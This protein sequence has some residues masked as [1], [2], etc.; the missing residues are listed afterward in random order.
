MMLNPFAR[1]G[2][3][4]ENRRGERWAWANIS[5]GQRCGISAN[6]REA[7]RSVSP[8]GN[9]DVMYIWD[10]HTLKEPPPLTVNMLA[11]HTIV[12]V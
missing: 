2:E 3:R 4:E 8:I 10:T 9:F 7:F 1:R 5:D 6:G 12:R 11:F